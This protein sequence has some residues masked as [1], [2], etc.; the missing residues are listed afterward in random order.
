MKARIM[1]HNMGQSSLWKEGGSATG[2]KPQ[3][4]WQPHFSIFANPNTVGL[5]L[6]GKNGT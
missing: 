3:W 6:K 5:Q 1:E 4:Q 2:V